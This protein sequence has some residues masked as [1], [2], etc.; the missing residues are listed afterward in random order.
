MKRIL[1][2]ILML[3]MLFSAAMAEDDPM[4]QLEALL[5]REEAIRLEMQ[6]VAL[7]LQLAEV[8]EDETARILADAKKLTLQNE[9]TTLQN[10][11]K[12]IAAQ[13][14]QAIMEEKS[15]LQEQAASLQAQMTTIQASLEENAAQQEALQALYEEYMLLGAFKGSATGFLS[16]VTVYVLLDDAGTISALHADTSRETPFMGSRC[17]EDEAFLSQFIGQAGPFTL[18][19]DVD[20]LSGATHTS[21]A[22]V[23]AIN[24]VFDQPEETADYTIARVEYSAAAK[25]L[26][27]DVWV[28]ITLDE[29]GAIS[30]MEV[31]CSGET[32]AIAAPCAQESFISQFIGRR[33]PFTDIDVVAGATFTSNAVIEAVNGLFN[34]EGADLK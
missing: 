11:K 10:S 17:G 24:S 16:E 28:T 5:K 31:D 23:N 7:E 29:N 33:G 12:G 4:A 20:A 15:L 3:L 27:S 18:N 19:V 30:A 1:S 13:A 26:L 8:N 2:G 21:Q 25:G 22:V 14:V 9:L 34:E 6:I 32:Q